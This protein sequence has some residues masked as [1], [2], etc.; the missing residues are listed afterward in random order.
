[1]RI[2]SSYVRVYANDPQDASCPTVYIAQDL[3]RSQIPMLN[4]GTYAHGINSKSN[5]DEAREPLPPQLLPPNQY[6][7]LSI[8][9][10]FELP[11]AL[12]LH[13]E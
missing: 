7:N 2:N 5:E 10:F 6:H 9:F 3:C 4:N 8:H 1:M 11:P 13:R 12:A